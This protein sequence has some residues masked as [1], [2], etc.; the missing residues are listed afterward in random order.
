MKPP[1]VQPEPDWEEFKLPFEIGSGRSMFVDTPAGPTIRMRFFKKCSDRSLIGRVWF[2]SATFGPPGF[3]HGG[4]VS[5]VLDEAMGTC[6]WIGGYPCIAANLSIDFV[7]MTPLEE[8]CLVEAK[9]VGV[10]PNKLVIETTLSLEGRVL[11]KG[12]GVFVRLRLDRIMSV[13]KSAGV[14]LPDLSDFKFAE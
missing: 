5:F 12:R 7:E 6:C 14:L 3:V 11:V 9:I 13:F 10:Q 2:G 4:L 1:T 8:D